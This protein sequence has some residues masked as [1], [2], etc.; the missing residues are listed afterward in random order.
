M[1]ISTLIG[2]FLLLVLHSP[3]ATE[4]S[5]L[6]L[7]ERQLVERG[8]P[9]AVIDGTK[10]YH[11]ASAR[12][13]AATYGQAIAAALAWH[14]AQLRWTGNLAVAVLDAEDWAELVMLPYPV[15]HAEL[16]W[17]LVVMPDS[18]ASFPGFDLWDFEAEALNVSLTFHEVGHIIANQLD[19][20]SDNHWIE[21]L[22]ADLFLAAYVRGERGD[23]AAILA[24]V[25]PR[26]SN[27][28]PYDQ[29]ADL[30]FFYA[31]VGLESYAWFQFRLAEA[32][33]RMLAG[34]RF[35]DIVAGLRREF[36]KQRALRRET[37]GRTLEHL[38]RIVPGA[39][40]ALADMAGDGVLPRLSPR[41][42]AAVP[43]PGNEART[44]ATLIVENRTGVPAR[45]WIEEVIAYNAAL[46]A[47]LQ[48]FGEDDDALARIIEDAVAAALASE[49]SATMVPPG[50]VEIIKAQSG[51]V[52]DLMDGTCLAFPA[53]TS[54]LIVS[55]ER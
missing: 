31:E 47:K 53:E 1:R 39:T 54:R 26:F 38:E 24:G 6:G 15:P 12:A 16:N 3:A 28:G 42:C 55:G 14:R 7:N 33:D 25:P 4:P 29:L 11:S 9:V 5:P 44:P 32:A 30:D 51:A 18:I 19:I 8:M 40:A 21:E 20:R 43:A 48:N 45:L 46:Q 17:N 23:L 13:Q 34:R 41:A 27:P 35:A 49:E 36:P 52:I 37:V 22:V 2:A 10:V 50:G